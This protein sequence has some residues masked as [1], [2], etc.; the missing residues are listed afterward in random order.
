[1]SFDLERIIAKIKQ[2]S[3]NPKETE[4]KIEIISKISILNPAFSLQN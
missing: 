4:N 1:M 3:A 2:A